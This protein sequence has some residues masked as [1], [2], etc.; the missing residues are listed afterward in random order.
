MKTRKMTLGAML[1][2]IGVVLGNIIYIPVG[3]S[4][5]F[6][7]QHSINLIAGI[8]LGPAY[9]VAIAFLISLIRNILGTGSL[10]AFPGS[11]LGALLVGLVYRRTKNKYLAG[12]GEV[13]GTGILGGMASFPLA[14]I[15]MG[16]E[17]MAFFFVYP[18]LLSSLGGSLI[19]LGLMRLIDFEKILKQVKIN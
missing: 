14:K 8:S 9:A 1:V 13:F 5:C 16:Q 11:M 15:L 6:F 3:M 12:L 7:V 4:K 10:L 2:S 17:V 18:F 19:A